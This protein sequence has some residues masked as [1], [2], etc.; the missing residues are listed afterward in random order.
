MVDSFLENP[1]SK[2]VSLKEL[3]LRSF[4]IP[5]IVNM[6]IRKVVKNKL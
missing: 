5:L 3:K 6:T 4:D 1:I 2:S